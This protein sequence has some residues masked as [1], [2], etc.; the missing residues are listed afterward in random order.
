M[1]N[2]LSLDFSTFFTGTEML[3]FLNV[4]IIRIVTSIAILFLGIISINMFTKIIVKLFTNS[5]NPM[6]ERKQKTLITISSISL[7]YSIYALVIFQILSVFNIASGSIV[8]IAGVGSLAIGFASQSLVKDIIIGIFILLEDQFAVGDFISIDNIS[9][10]VENIGV[11]TTTIRTIEG[12]LHIIPNSEIKTVT[13]MSKDFSRA[14][15]DVILPYTVEIDKVLDILNSE[16]T[17]QKE[18]IKQITKEPEVLGITKNILNFMEIRI[19]ADC[20]AGQSKIV[21]REIRKCIKIRFEQ[22]GV[23]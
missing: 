4:V 14:I 16:M 10:V 20:E 17:I 18:I 2:I 6:S 21:E 22:E 1:P 8:A 15:V 3:D 13:N 23:C 19:V 7:K 12:Y 11:R 5:K 9:G